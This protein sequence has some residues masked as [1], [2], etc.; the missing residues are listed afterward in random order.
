MAKEKKGLLGRLFGS[1]KPAPPT[2]AA[3][4]PVA[5]VWPKK[6][7]I[8]SLKIESKIGDYRAKYRYMD[9]R[10]KF[11]SNSYAPGVPVNLQPDGSAVIFGKTVGTFNAPRIQSMLKDWKDRNEPVVCKL[12]EM[13]EDG[14]GLVYIAFYKVPNYTKERI[15]KVSGT[16]SAEH[17]DELMLLSVGDELELEES[18]DVSGRVE[19]SDLGYLDSK[20]STWALDELNLEFCEATV[21]SVEEN[22]NGKL[23]LTVRIR[24]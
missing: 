2:P 8:F 1:Q 18:V 3:P 17:Q 23:V 9:L 19:V 13:N 12:Y 5:E 24:Y 14:S 4:P 22:D 6:V 7:H 20:D 10:V 15:C 21:A 16:G 11:D